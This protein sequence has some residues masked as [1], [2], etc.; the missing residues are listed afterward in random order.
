MYFSLLRLR[1]LPY[2]NAN[3]KSSEVSYEVHEEQPDIDKKRISVHFT[4]Q[5][6]KSLLFGF[7]NA[8]GVLGIYRPSGLGIVVYAGVN[9]QEIDLQYQSLALSLRKGRYGRSFFTMGA[10][11]YNYWLLPTLST[12]ELSVQS[13][14][15]GANTSASFVLHPTVAY[16]LGLGFAGQSTIKKQKPSVPNSDIQ[17][18]ALPAV[19]ETALTI[20]VRNSINYSLSFGNTGVYKS[21]LRI[22]IPYIVD[23]GNLRVN[24]TLRLYDILGVDLTLQGAFVSAPVHH[25][26]WLRLGFVSSFMRTAPRPFYAKAKVLEGFYNTTARALVLQRRGIY[27]LHTSIGDMAYALSLEYRIGGLSNAAV[28]FSG[29][30]F[31]DLGAAANAYEDLRTNTRHT[32]GPGILFHFL[33]PL[34]IDCKFSLGFGGHFLGNPDGRAL[35]FSFSVAAH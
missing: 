34:N 2:V 20:D 27:P 24:D 17:Q 33:D 15:Y 28:A 1:E 19:G 13:V 25:A 10:N 7:G 9:R 31:Y 32:V 8:Y 11:L 35:S 14:L 4:L 26:L 29:F 18:S 5:S 6:R 12:A 22:S 23:F 3:H 30:V 16:K 21:L